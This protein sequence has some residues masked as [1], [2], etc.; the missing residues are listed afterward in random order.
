VN[1]EAAPC[2]TPLSIE[3]NTLVGEET[4]PLLC[5]GDAHW[6]VVELTIV[7]GSEREVEPAW[8]RQV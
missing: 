2:E 1:V 3:I 6:K 8:R 4:N 7:A 5:G